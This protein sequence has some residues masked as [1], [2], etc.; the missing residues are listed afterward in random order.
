MTQTSLSANS[1]SFNFSALVKD[2][3]VAL[4]IQLIGL[5]LICLV[6]VFL[7]RWMGKTEYVIY[8]YVISWSLLLAI[9]AV[10]GFPSTV[11]RLISEYRVKQDWGRLGGIIRGSLLLTI[12]ASIFLCLVSTALIL[13]LDHYFSFAYTKPLLIGI[14]LVPL[15]ALVQ[16][17]LETA[18]GMKDLT[19]AY[20]PFL[21][22]W[23]I[24]L[25][26]GGLFFWQRNH[27]LGSITTIEMAM[28]MLAIALSFQFSLLWG[29]LNTEVEESTPIYNYREWIRIALVLLLQRGFTQI[30]N[31]T[32]IVMV[33]SI[34]GTEE[35]GIYTAAAKTSEWVVFALQT[36]NI[37]V[38][39]TFTTLFVQGDRQELQK[40]VFKVS[41]WVFWFSLVVATILIIFA[42]PVMELFGSDFVAAHW[43]LKILVLGQ[44]VNAL[45]GSVG[46]LL[47]MTGN[48]NKMVF[49]SG[50][51][52]LI[53]IILN[54][55]LIPI[56]GSV[57]AAIATSL[58]ITMWNIWVGFVVIKNLGIYP[59][60]LY[61][62]FA[63]G[64]R[65][66]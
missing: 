34:A 6:K 48:Q 27:A 18:R 50:Y 65:K 20:V 29:K 44:V 2:V 61:S 40:L 42:K 17:F 36:V 58:T 30:L 35:A 43:Q 46:T 16:L 14:W 41:I 15:Q 64:R 24:L 22:I 57:G 51:A 28:V 59:S 8:E 23:P 9:P 3:K 33:G 45:C 10:L 62:F 13:L 38:A 37:V 66:K 7:A 60:V 25:L 54:G 32:D 31:Q 53:N 39:P 12:L 11:L 5:L 26:S 1:D 63:E 52:A 56:F 19:L 55:V 4:I 49:I 21:V 47:I